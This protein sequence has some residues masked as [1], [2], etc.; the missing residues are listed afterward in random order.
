[1]RFVLASDSDM[2]M[3]SSWGND[4]YRTARRT[5]HLDDEHVWD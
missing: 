1:M 4:D 2:T 5:A 3:G